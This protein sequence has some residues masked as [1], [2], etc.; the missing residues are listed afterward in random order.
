VDADILLKN[1]TNKLLSAF[2]ALVR[3]QFSKSVSWLVIHPKKKLLYYRLGGKMMKAKFNHWIRNF[4]Y[5]IIVAGMIF[6]LCFGMTGSVAARAQAVETY[7]P[8][9]TVNDCQTQTSTPSHTPTSTS[10]P[11][12]V[13]TTAAAFDTSLAPGAMATPTSVF[14]PMIFEGNS[15]S[16]TMSRNGSPAPFALTMYANNPYS[17][18]LDW[19][20]K[21][22]ANNG[23]ASASGTGDSQA[24]HYT[25]NTDY[26]GTDSFVVQAEENTVLRMLSLSMFSSLKKT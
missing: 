10:T 7:T 13:P 18:P 8:T 21:S 20:I 4:L 11:T 22:P 6:S 14:P 2:S 1:C 25:A 9:E 17:D 23:T 26:T 12:A 19:S 16:V 3:V 5:G 15:T 24:I